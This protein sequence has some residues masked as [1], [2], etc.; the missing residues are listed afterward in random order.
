MLQKNEQLESQLKETASRQQAQM[1]MY[2]TMINSLKA[3]ELSAPSDIIVAKIQESERMAYEGEINELKEHRK[4]L[5]ED[6]LDRE[7]EFARLTNDK[8][9]FIKE[10]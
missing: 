8:D 1:Q 4:K 6:I 2:E 7:R 5:Q 3:P 9:S 10:L